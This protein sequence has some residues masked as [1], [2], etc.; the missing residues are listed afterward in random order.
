MLESKWGLRLIALALAVFFF[1]SANNVFGNMFN[2]D[3]F[4]QKSTETIESVPVETK[5]DNDK[6][7][8]NNV[9]GKVD[10]DISGPQ[11]QVLKAENGQNIKVS[12]DLSGAK[13]GKHTAQ[14]KV[15]GLSK[16]IDY[17]VKP[18]EATINL[19]EKVTKEIKVDPD[20]SI[21]NIDSDYMIASQSVSPE[22]VKVTGGQTQI[23]KIAYLKAH[24]KNKSKI[25]K[26]TTDLANIT[27]FDRN[28]NKLNVSIRPDEVNLT[29]KVKPYSKKVKI[30][31]KTTGSLANG[32]DLDTIKLDKDEVEI[33]GNREDLQNIDSITGEVNLDDI[34]DTTDR[35]VYFKPPKKISKVQPDNTTAKVTVK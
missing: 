10:V 31:T 25:A 30:K 11:S 8:A 17:K 15:S 2:A 1:L 4:S 24:Y 29:T 6:L 32:K 35:D 20:V 14:Y 34:S 18:K 27:A 5:Y 26:N 22:K 7:Y 19:E 23:D 28:L 13:A 12:L 33:F 3:K 16:D 21:D 9:P